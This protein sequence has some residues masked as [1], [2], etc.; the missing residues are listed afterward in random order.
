[1]RA[2]RSRYTKQPQEKITL[3]ECQAYVVGAVR[4]MLVGTRWALILSIVGIVLGGAALVVAI[5]R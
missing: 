5:T 1:V 3:G 2:E 4:P